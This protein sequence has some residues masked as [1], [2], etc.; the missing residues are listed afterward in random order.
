[1]IYSLTDYGR[2]LQP[3][4]EEVKVWGR[5]HITRQQSQVSAAAQ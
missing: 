2:Q 3:L 5:K 4:L 1:M